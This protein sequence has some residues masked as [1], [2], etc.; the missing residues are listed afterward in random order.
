MGRHAGCAAGDWRCMY[1]GQ[2]VDEFAFAFISP[3][4]RQGEA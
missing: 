2:D 4:S 1:L 3:L